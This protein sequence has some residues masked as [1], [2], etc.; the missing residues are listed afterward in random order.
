[1]VAHVAD[2]DECRIVVV[3]AMAFGEEAV[4]T[5]RGA[6]RWWLTIAAAIPIVVSGAFIWNAQLD[7]L[8][9]LKETSAKL[10]SRLVEARLSGFP[11]VQRKTMRGEPGETDLAELQLQGKV[12]EV[13]ER[14]GDDLKTLHAKGVAYLL[15]AGMAKG[16]DRKGQVA[17]DRKNAV[18]ALEKAADRAPDDVTYQSDLA[19]ALIAIGDP[20]NLKRAI[21]DRALKADPRSAEALFN[22]A[23]ALELLGQTDEAISAYKRYLAVDSSSPW[24][25]EAREHIKS[26]P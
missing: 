14:R 25:E 15:A 5:K 3:D 20:A 22:R 9:P 6:G 18:V 2:C 26:L 7:P 17:E 13:L 21:C 8:K 11:H 4:T 10:D 16:E 24:A 23:K 1:V 19:A 12:A